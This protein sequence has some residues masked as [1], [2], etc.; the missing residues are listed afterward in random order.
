LQR[1]DGRLGSARLHI[2]QQHLAASLRGHLRDAPAHGTG[3]NYSHGFKDGL[4]MKVLFG[5]RPEQAMTK[6]SNIENKDA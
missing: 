1:L 2:E 6:C 5:F 4:H 3:A